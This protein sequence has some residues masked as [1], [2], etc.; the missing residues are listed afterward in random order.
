VARLGKVFRMHGL[1]QVRGQIDG[2]TFRSSFMA[3]GGGTHS[4][5]VKSD[6]WKAIGKGVGDTVTVVLQEA[7]AR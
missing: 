2:H 1:V 4:L 7:L 6:L 5:R 3:L